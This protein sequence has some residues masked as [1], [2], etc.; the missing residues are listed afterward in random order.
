MNQ[1]RKA[2]KL[3]LFEIRRVFIKSTWKPSTISEII[4]SMVDTNS[5]ARIVLDT[6]NTKHK[7]LADMFRIQYG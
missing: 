6:E 5:V 4:K 3:A 2:I 1:L 7:Q